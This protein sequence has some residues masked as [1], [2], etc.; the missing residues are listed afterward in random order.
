MTASILK[1]DPNLQKAKKNAYLIWQNIWIFGVSP[2]F[3]QQNN[4]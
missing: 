1:Q 4:T 2:F 3:K